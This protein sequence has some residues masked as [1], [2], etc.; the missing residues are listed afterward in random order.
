MGYSSRIIDP[1][2]LGLILRDARMKSGLT[3]RQLA[4]EL[5]VSQRYV[6]ELE[7]GKPTKAIERLLDFAQVTGSAFRLESLQSEQPATETAAKA[8]GP[9]D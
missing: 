1:A 5:G 6:V 7:A 3:Q 4:E 8:G 9:D 2:T